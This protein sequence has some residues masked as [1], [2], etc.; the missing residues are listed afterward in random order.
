MARHT[1]LE[2]EAIRLLDAVSSGMEMNDSISAA[3]L[4]MLPKTVKVFGRIAPDTQTDFQKRCAKMSDEEIIHLNATDGNFFAQFMLGPTFKFDFPPA[5][6]AVWNVLTQ[7][8][9]T[10]QEYTGEAK[11]ALGIPRGFA[12]TTLMKLFCAYALIHSRHT[13]ILAISNVGTNAEKTIKDVADLMDQPQV[14]KLYGNYDEDIDVDR[15][16]EKIFKFGGKSCVLKAK[17]QRSS[18]RGVNIGNRRPD[19]ILMDDVQDEENA[20]SGLESEALLDWILNTLLPAKSTDGGLDIFV[21]NT[22]DQAGAILPKLVNDPEWVSLV[23]GAILA[24]G[25]SLWERLHPVAKLMSAY[26]SA[27]RFGNE[28]GWLAQYMNIMDVGKNAKFD[29]R[30]LSIHWNDFLSKHH[31]TDESLQ[32]VEIEGKFVIIDPSS[33]KEAADEHSILC[34]YIIAGLPVCRRVVHKQ[35]TPKEAISTGLAM[36]VQ[37]NCFVLFIEDV[38]YQDTLLYWFKEYL[39]ALRLPPVV[40]KMFQ[41]LP[42]APERK[43]KTARILNCFRQMNVGEIIC[44]PDVHQAIIGEGRSFNRLKTN[45][46]DNVLDTVHY[47][48]LLATSHKAVILDSYYEANYRAQVAAQQARLD[49]P[50]KGKAR[51]ERHPV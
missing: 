30:Q 50:S 7:A 32:D 19:I 47:A 42:V 31:I 10:L 35:L 12:K 29:A 14:R 6:I 18:V 24:D 46:E 51:H 27:V 49:H 45:N 28:G 38:A 43:H 25:T 4:S 13:F 36:M 39:D 5:L 11:L 17:G 26:R 33:T 37:E 34:V 40:R 2:A 1:M 21:G 3:E 22:Y 20:K 16:D 15:Q 44:H 8:L 41:I 23:L 48:P 9:A